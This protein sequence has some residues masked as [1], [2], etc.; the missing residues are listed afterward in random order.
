MLSHLTTALSLFLV[1]KN[2]NKEQLSLASQTF[3]RFSSFLNSFVTP[4][5][6]IYWLIEIAS[7]MNT[8]QTRPF[9]KPCFLVFSL[10]PLKKGHHFNKTVGETQK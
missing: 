5:I 7:V 10:E 4:D 6:I 8:D 9:A 3:L 1:L 2:G